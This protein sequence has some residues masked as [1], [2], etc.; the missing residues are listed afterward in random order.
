[1]PALH[2][3]HQPVC[4]GCVRPFTGFLANGAGTHDAP[5]SDGHTAVAPGNLLALGMD[6]CCDISWP[7]LILH[8]D[9]L[10]QIPLVDLC[11]YCGTVVPIGLAVFGQ[12]ARE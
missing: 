11:I 12:L 4:S 5:Y 7:G 8:R 1:M 10:G 9:G 6:R 2:R 3:V